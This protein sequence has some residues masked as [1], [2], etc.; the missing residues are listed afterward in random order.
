MSHGS[1][2][3]RRSAARDLLPRVL[4]G[5]LALALA[6][7]W[8]L[9]PHTP[10]E[11]A[12]PPGLESPSPGE[13][14]TADGPYR[15][16]AF[17]EATAGEEVRGME[18][19][20]LADGEQLGDVRALEFLESVDA[21][22]G[23]RRTRWTTKLDPLAAWWNEGW[24]LRNG[25]YRLEV[26]ALLAIQG[27][28]REPT[29]WRGNDFVVDVDPPT[30]TVTASVLEASER[31]VEVAWDAVPLPDFRRYLVQRKIGDGPWADYREVA[32][33]EKTRWADVLPEDGTYAYRVEVYRSGA[34]GGERRSGWSEPASLTVRKPLPPP[35]APPSPE[36]D[37]EQAGA[38]DNRPPAARQ[39]PA[40]RRSVWT[41]PD[42]FEEV[43]D[44]GVDPPPVATGPEPEEPQAEQPAPDDRDGVLVVEGGERD[45]A[46]VL[47][48]VAAGLLLTVSAWH[49]RRFMRT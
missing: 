12:G 6:L 5:A 44:Y 38:A 42:T 10:A 15:V 48:P 32:D 9:L 27:V 49:V 7:A 26:R 37:G 35:T 45:L 17:V 28:P 23:T 11:A 8:L 47:G 30:T 1:A 4:R 19:R 18:A 33:V 13:R 29:E 21:G 16:V 22:P 14:I 40:P 43:L 34:D 20:L 39:P 25:P 46:Q 24:A 41:G 36:P 3:L 2:A 31:K